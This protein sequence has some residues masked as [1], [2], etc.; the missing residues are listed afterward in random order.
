MLDE[1]QNNNHFRIRVNRDSGDYFV[2]A[3][4]VK[5]E[6]TTVPEPSSV[7]MLGSG[8]AVCLVGLRNRRK[9]SLKK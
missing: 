2:S 5:L 7:L 3:V 6:G 9:L 4:D 8:L 1:I